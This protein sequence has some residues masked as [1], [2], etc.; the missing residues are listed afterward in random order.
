MDD[1]TLGRGVLIMDRN[2][3]GIG[4]SAVEHIDP[5][6]LEAGVTIGEF[7]VVLPGAKVREGTVIPPFS[8]VTAR[9]VI[10]ARNTKRLIK[11]EQEL[12]Y[13]SKCAYNIPIHTVGFGTL[14]L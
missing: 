5:V 8:V 10:T 1:V 2:H 14:P 6:I 4:A 3:H 7:S 9:S 11:V 13:R 12:E